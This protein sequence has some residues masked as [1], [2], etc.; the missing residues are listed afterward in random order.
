MRASLILNI[1]H[2]NINLVCRILHLFDRTYGEQVKSMFLRVTVGDFNTQTNQPF[3]QTN[4]S[5]RAMVEDSLNPGSILALIGNATVRYTNGSYD[6]LI[7]KID[8]VDDN[9]GEL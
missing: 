4:H 7:G 9:L 2:N 6:I 1:N 5:I 8:T 3:P